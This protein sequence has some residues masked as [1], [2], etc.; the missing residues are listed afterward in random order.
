MRTKR[1]NISLD[2]KKK[3]ILE[4]ERNPKRSRVD[5][6][7]EF[8]MPESTIKTILSK[9]QQIKEAAEKFGTERKRRF[10]I[11]LKK[12]KDFICN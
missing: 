1:K 8:Q 10:K 9:K 11:Q 12:E 6:A 3:I 7:K 2:I 5:L 4:F